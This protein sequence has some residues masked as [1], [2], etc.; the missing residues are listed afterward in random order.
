MEINEMIDH[1]MSMLESSDGVSLLLGI[2]TE[3]M[4][5]KLLCYGN[6]KR[7]LAMMAKEIK[8]ISL[9]TGIPAA[10]ICADLYHVIMMM[11]DKQ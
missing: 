10:S 11:E 2:H 4:G 5:L 7:I 1:L 8:Q 3:D 6:G 9:D